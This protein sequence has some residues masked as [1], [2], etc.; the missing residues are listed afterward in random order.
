MFSVPSPYPI[1]HSPSVEIPI[2]QLLKISLKILLSSFMIPN[3]AD[4]LNYGTIY[5]YVFTRN[6]AKFD[7]ETRIPT[8]SES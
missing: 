7:E 3:Q 5:T 8:S 6:L 2:L 4:S 1:K